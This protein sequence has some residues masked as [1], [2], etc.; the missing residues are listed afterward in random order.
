MGLRRLL[1]RGKDL[2]KARGR[3]TGHDA[4]PQSANSIV[5]GNNSSPKAKEDISHS[6]IGEQ[7]AN[8]TEDSVTGCSL[9]DKAYGDLKNDAESMKCIDAYER[10]L[11]DELKRKSPLSKR[12]SPLLT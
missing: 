1:K 7:A 11:L 8:V 9:W 5:A 4:V 6:T 10:L 2:T 3:S 12:C